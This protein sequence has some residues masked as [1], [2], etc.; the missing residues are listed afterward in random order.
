MTDGSIFKSAVPEQPL[1]A[2]A[3]EATSPISETVHAHDELPPSLYLE[4]NKV[5]LVLEL[6]GGTSAY[7]HFDMTLLTREVDRYIIEDMERKG[8]QDMRAEYQNLVDEALKKL[9]LP[10]GT[11][12][13][14]MI[15]KLVR[16]F[17]IQHKLYTALREREELMQ[18]DPADMTSTQLRHYLEAHGI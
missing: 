14:T 8:L 7:E 1:T 9:D 6:I 5:P 15:E 4:A 18:K 2:P 11:D 3:P 16:H 10:D 12:V 13:Y 17:R